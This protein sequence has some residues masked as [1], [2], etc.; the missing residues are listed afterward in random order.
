MKLLLATCLALLGLRPEAAGIQKVLWQETKEIAERHSSD[1][2]GFF[3]SANAANAA[4]NSVDTG[5]GEAEDA[6]LPEDEDVSVLGEDC[7]VFL[8]VCDRSHRSSNYGTAFQ[9][10]GDVQQQFHDVNGEEVAADI[11]ADVARD[12]ADVST[13]NAATLN[14]ATLNAAS[15]I[16]YRLNPTCMQPRVYLEQ[17]REMGILSGSDDEYE[18]EYS[19]DEEEGSQPLSQLS[20][21]SNKARQI[22]DSTSSS[23]GDVSLVPSRISSFTPLTRPSLW[24]PFCLT[25]TG[26]CARPGE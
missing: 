20:Q 8:L 19:D 13:L 4:E 3:A 23:N 1:I 9:L 14:A 11:D 7:S 24:M 15:S 10:G 12:E 22:V 6:S 2:R 25:E 5:A 21:E 18:F 26:V 16:M 17:R